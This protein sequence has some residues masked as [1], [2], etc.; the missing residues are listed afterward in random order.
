MQF[1][2]PV[3]MW[4]AA[5]LNGMVKL[6]RPE[7]LYSIVKLYFKVEFYIIG[8]YYCTVEVYSK[9][10]AVQDNIVLMARAPVVSL[11]HQ[12]RGWE[13]FWKIN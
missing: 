10:I 2:C 3:E 7:K 11:T 1:N 9:H 5:L 8:E 13:G 6:Y 4:N 12:L